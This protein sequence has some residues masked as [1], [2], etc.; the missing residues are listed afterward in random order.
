MRSLKGN[1]TNELTKQKQT[2]RLREWTYGDQGW[3][4][5]KGIVRE[6]GM[7][8][9]TLL[10]LKQT[11][12]PT[13]QHMKLMLSL[14]WPLDGRGVWARMDTCT[15]MAEPLCCTPKTITGLTGCACMCPKLLQSCL[16]FCDPMD[17]SPHQAPLSM[18]FSRQEYLNG[19]PCPP[20]E[21]PPN[22][23]IEP[24]FLM[25][26]ALGGGFLTTSANWEAP[27]TSY[28]PYKRKN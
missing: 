7:D 27:L 3:G 22:P 10:H 28:T 8:M 24:M 9:C 5:G 14:T 15:C 25:S 6:F 19:L 13:V 21:D 23:G 20:P 11:T 17:C 2:H 12:G 4:M 26:P 1:D 16:T 18:G